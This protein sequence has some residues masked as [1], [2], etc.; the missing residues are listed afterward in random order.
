[1]RLFTDK[2]PKWGLIPFK[3]RKILNCQMK[4]KAAAIFKKRLQHK[5]TWQHW[6]TD[7]GAYSGQR[8]FQRPSFGPSLT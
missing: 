2:T 6:F 7:T 8:T 5:A 3:N 1:M 4:Q